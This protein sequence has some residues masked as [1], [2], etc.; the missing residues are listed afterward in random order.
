[1]AFCAVHALNSFLGYAATSP[2]QL[3]RFRTDPSLLNCLVFSGE[4]T[5]VSALDDPRPLASASLLSADDRQHLPR[6][7][8]C[9]RI[10]GA[11][12]Q[13]AFGH[14]LVFASTAAARTTTPALIAGL[15]HL[16]VTWGP[17]AFFCIAPGH[18]FTVR[19]APGQHQ[20]HVID[21]L[22]RGS[23]PL[24]DASNPTVTY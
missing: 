20:W 1:M 5:P 17:S 19:L 6:G 7:E 22:R 21:S 13:R 18:F 15:D 14:H 16:A 2:E 10:V 8:F 24:T 23:T 12:L 9:V 11:W 4:G 3:L